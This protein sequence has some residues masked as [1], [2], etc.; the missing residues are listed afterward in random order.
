MK[1]ETYKQWEEAVNHYRKIDDLLKDKKFEEAKQEA[2]FSII[3]GCA[4]IYVLSEELKMPDLK[5]IAINA[6]QDLG[7][8]LISKEHYTPKEIIKWARRTLKKLSDEC[9]PDTFHPLR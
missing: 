2:I 6:F 9:P 4:G 1:L 3:S 8:K 7:E 5:V